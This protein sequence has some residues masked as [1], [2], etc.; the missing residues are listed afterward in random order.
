VEILIAIG[1][2]FSYLKCTTFILTVKILHT[3]PSLADRFNLS[4]HIVAIWLISTVFSPLFNDFHLL[5]MAP[6]AIIRT[7]IIVLQWLL[8]TAWTVAYLPHS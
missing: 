7:V 5:I 3:N 4:K 6:L 2:L 8:L 1:R